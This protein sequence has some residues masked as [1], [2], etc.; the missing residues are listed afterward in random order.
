MG[1]NGMAGS[2]PY[3]GGVE[4]LTRLIARLMMP[5]LLLLLGGAP[6]LAQASGWSVSEAKG[7][8]VVIDAQGQRPAK[9]GTALAA[10]ATIRTEARSSAVLVRGR[11]FVTM[12]QNAQ[13]RIP[14]PAQAQA[15]SRGI[16]QIIQDYGS[17]L[18]NIGKKENPHFGVE[19]PYMAAVV[20]GTTFVIT[21]SGEG[22]S[23]QVT[24]GAV[25]AATNDGGVRELIRPG[26]VAM[27]A[28]GDPLR[29]V[30]E[31]EGRRVLDS[32]AR[33]AG[34]GPAAATPA[35]AS[36]SGSAGTPATPEPAVSSGRGQ[37]RIERAIVSTP[38]DIGAYS[39]GFASGEVAV[40]AAAVVADNTG[41]GNAPAVDNSGGRAVDDAVCSGA[42][43]A[44]GGSGNGGG[45]GNGNGNGNVGAG[46]NG[47]GVGNGAN[48]NGNGNGN[49]G[50]PGNAGGNNPGDGGKDEGDGDNGNGGGNGNGGDNGNG[51]GGDDG[52]PG[53]GNGNGKGG[54]DGDPGNGGSNGGGNG[55]GNDGNDGN[56]GNG[57][58]PGNGNGNG[59]G[60]G[61]GNGNGNGN[62]GGG[63]RGGGG[64]IE[65]RIRLGGE[66]GPGLDVGL[67]PDPVALRR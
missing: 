40:M 42:T 1:L 52:K 55:N 26:A 46:D 10:G 64:G 3:G 30:V 8:V 16:I 50:N 41:R 33:P 9:A 37:A 53:N 56:D 24:E 20:K 44:G 22:A 29:M 11:E 48:G 35:P 67:T 39:R 27:I 17:A 4:N 63:N 23:L 38:G 59:N 60:N 15:R 57:G 34:G 28:A 45:N 66:G 6:A 36:G 47:A 18:F 7:V 25:E 58:N 51:K 49:D 5:I 62:D 31:G 65:I 43:C 14:A 21:V 19:T 61:I 2:L 32:P 54:D 13:L 12:R